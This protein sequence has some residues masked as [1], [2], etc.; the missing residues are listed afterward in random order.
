ML[1]DLK[2]DDLPIGQKDIAELIG[3][4]NYKKLVINFGGSDVYIQKE[5]TLTKELRNKKII[6][7]FN[8]DNYL[9]LAIKFKLSERAVR[10]IISD[11]L[12]MTGV[13]QLTIFDK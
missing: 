12:K 4:E 11:N 6:E 7:M 13:E 8:G 1:D 9:E 2:L 3:L 5:D 10:G